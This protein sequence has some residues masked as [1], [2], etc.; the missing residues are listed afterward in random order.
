MSRSSQTCQKRIKRIISNDFHSLFPQMDKKDNEL[1]D[2]AAEN[3]ALS[4][5]LFAMEDEMSTKDQQIEDLEFD[6]D[7][8]ARPTPKKRKM[9]EDFC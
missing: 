5:R 8:L 7:S 6:R 1:W 3:G 4:D 2:A 9:N